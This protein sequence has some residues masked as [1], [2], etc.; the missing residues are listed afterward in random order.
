MRCATLCSV[1]SLGCSADQPSPHIAW[2]TAN[3]KMPKPKIGKRKAKLRYNALSDA[4][5]KAREEYMESQD[6]VTATRLD[7]GLVVR[8]CPVTHTA[9]PADYASTVSGLQVWGLRRRQT[10]YTR[11]RSN[12]GY[13]TI[14]RRYPYVLQRKRNFHLTRPVIL[15]F[16][17]PAMCQQLRQ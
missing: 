12:S 17:R 5:I 9:Q 14:Q 16:N 7:W 13:K 10:V 15:I 2:N 6:R 11:N 1:W 4:G 3:L 8:H